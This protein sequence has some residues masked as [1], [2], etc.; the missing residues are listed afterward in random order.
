MR[1]WSSRDRVKDFVWLKEKQINHDYV[2]EANNI[3]IIILHISILRST[4]CKGTQFQNTEI[5][6]YLIF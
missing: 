2:V 4:I 3:T 6:K 5:H 1:V